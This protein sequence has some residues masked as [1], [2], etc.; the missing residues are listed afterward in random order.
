[1]TDYNLFRTF[2]KQIFNIVL[3]V[4]NTNY[5]QMYLVKKKITVTIIFYKIYVYIEVFNEVIPVLHRIY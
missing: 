2:I 3:F 4:I 5:V 1:M